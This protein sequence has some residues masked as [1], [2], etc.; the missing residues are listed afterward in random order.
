MKKCAFCLF[1]LQILYHNARF[2][3]RKDVTSQTN[4]ILSAM[5]TQFSHN[6][7]CLNRKTVL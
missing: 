6:K 3:N 7:F 1:L 2:K 4:A 5:R